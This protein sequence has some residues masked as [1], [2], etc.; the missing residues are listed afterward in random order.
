MAFSPTP[1]ARHPTRGFA[2]LSPDERRRAQGRDSAP[3][4]ADRRLNPATRL[5]GSR[6]MSNV[7]HVD[8]RKTQ[9]PAPAFTDDWP[10]AHGPVHL[11]MRTAPDHLGRQDFYALWRDGD[12]AKRLEAFLGKSLVTV[13]A[14]MR[15][16]GV[17]VEVVDRIGADLRRAP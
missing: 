5:V 7:I 11:V 16:H 2:S 14:H 3:S 12:G 9:P 17:E 10:A 15:D 13:R 1:L 4:Q 8:F 6:T